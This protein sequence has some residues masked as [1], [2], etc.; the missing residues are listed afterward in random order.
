[1]DQE[2]VKADVAK[3][4]LPILVER[5]AGPGGTV[6]ITQAQYDE[7]ARRHGGLRA[8]GVKID[9]QDGELRLSLTRT[10]RPPLS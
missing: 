1:M 8:V 6:T 10:E 9:Y 7:F 5:L 3:L 2:D 4:A